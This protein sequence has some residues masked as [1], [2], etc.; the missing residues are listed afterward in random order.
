[1][2]ACYTIDMNLKRVLAITLVLGIIAHGFI[3]WSKKPYIKNAD[4][5]GS[6][7]IAF[8][9]SL[10]Y[11]VGSTSGNDMFSLTGK[12]LGIT[13]INKGVPGDTTRDGLMRFDNDVVNNNPR[14]VFILLGGNDYLQKVPEE[15]TFKNL[16]TMIQ[17]AQGAGAAVILLGVRGGVFV[18]KF[19]EHYKALAQKYDCLYVPNVLEGI[20]LNRDLMYDSIHPN[21]KG[22]KIVAVRLEAALKEVID[23]GQN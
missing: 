1:M 18:D 5:A 3:F 7:I 8:G 19:A 12:A 11:G 21:D 22:Y 4:S 16:E 13:I 2:G 15:E 9:D 23:A 6:N 20:V 14:I 10:V 17:N